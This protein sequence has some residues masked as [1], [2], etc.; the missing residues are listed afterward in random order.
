[1]PADTAREHWLVG[2]QAAVAAE[3]ILDAAGECFA[4]QG[5]AGTSI[6][7]IA[8]AAGC[9]RPTVYRYFAD[10]DALRRAFVQREARRLGAAV[11]H[12]VAGIDD[13]RERLVA[14]VLAAVRGV[15]ANPTLA[16]WFAPGDAGMTSDLARE[17]EVIESLAAGFLGEPRDADTRAKARWVVR[18]V[19][20]LLVMP[21][22]N[23][24]DERTM[25][26]R[27]VV[28]VVT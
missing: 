5:V 4:A 1:M 25:L 16:A 14:A 11:G 17:S 28:P 7:D 10:R 2:D 9:S 6:G 22:R 23:A 18:V 24:A 19:V 26:E 20:S 27:F 12:K 21:G 8:A 3:R 15:R 13:R